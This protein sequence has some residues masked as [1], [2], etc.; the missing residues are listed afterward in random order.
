M[1]SITGQLRRVLKPTGTLWWN[2]GDAYLG[3][4]KGSGDSN[5][6]PKYTNKARSRNLPK[7]AG[8][9]KCLM[10]QNY[11]LAIRMIDEQ[12]WILRNSIIWQKPNVMPSSVKDRFTVDYEPVFFFT[13]SK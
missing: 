3:S 9:Q 1:L 8:L 10:L 12:G 5:P 11:R 2:H 7:A 13:K 6:D 4:G